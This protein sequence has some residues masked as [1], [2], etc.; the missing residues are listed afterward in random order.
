MFVQ[1]MIGEYGSL[2]KNEVLVTNMDP[3]E[4]N[5]LYVLNKLP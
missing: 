2:C 3:L 4:N 5:F 1:G